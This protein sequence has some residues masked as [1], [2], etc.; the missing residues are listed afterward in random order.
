[1]RVQVSRLFVVILCLGVRGFSRSHSFFDFRSSQSDGIGQLLSPDLNT[2][3][4]CSVCSNGL[5]Q[6]REGILKLD[7]SFFC[8]PNVITRSYLYDG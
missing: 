7:Y 8:F 4:K 6:L 1:M 5:L 2:R 3:L